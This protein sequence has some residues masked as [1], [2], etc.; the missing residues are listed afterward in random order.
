MKGDGSAMWSLMW[1]YCISVRTL[2]YQGMHVWA[3][4]CP[5]IAWQVGTSEHQVASL[6]G[7]WE[8]WGSSSP[9][10]ADM[11][12]KKSHVRT[13]PEK[14]SLQ[15]GG[16]EENGRLVREIVGT[17]LGPGVPTGGFQWQ[18]QCAWKLAFVT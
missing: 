18:V 13:S 8:V 11:E 12:G 17:W 7:F 4:I 1:K 9:G 2:R 16:R 6:H 3:Q 10:G 5:A 14:L 15:W